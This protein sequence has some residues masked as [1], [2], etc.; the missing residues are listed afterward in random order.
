MVLP[1]LHRGVGINVM[2]CGFTQIFIF[3]RSSRARDQ[4]YDDFCGHFFFFA[5]DNVLLCINYIDLA[6]LSNTY[7]YLLLDVYTEKQHIFNKFI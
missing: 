2:F 6:G 5:W 7:V 1:C 3:F 4:S